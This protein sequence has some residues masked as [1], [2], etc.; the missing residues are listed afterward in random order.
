MLGR[1]GFDAGAMDRRLTFE[2]Y[3]ETNT[4]L[5]PTQG[6]GGIG[7]VWGSR[8]DVSDGEKMAAGGVM[9]TIVARF[10]VR[11]SALTRGLTAKDRLTEGGRV[12]MIAG[13][14]ELDRRGFLE[15]TA[16]ARADG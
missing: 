5:G 8:R 11:S 10:V 9:A 7:T 16:E 1:G 3:S 15:I 12:F 6:W 14:K 13:I 4:S 2:R